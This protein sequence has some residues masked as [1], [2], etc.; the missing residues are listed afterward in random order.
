MKNDWKKIKISKCGK[1][2]VKTLFHFNSTWA[3]NHVLLLSEVSF[4]VY[5]VERWWSFVGTRYKILPFFCILSYSNCFAFFLSPFPFLASN[6]TTSNK[7]LLLNPHTTTPSTIF[8]FQTQKE[9]KKNEN[10]TAVAEKKKG[11]KVHTKRWRSKHKKKIK[12]YINIYVNKEKKYISI[13]FSSNANW[14]FT[15]PSLCVPFSIK[16]LT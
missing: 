4:T 11:K 6:A 10:Y 13:P 16:Q 3:H 2:N 15:S 8:Q 7:N 12:K 5:G 9:K 1:Q 14:K